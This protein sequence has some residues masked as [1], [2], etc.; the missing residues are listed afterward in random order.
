MKNFFFESILSENS[1]FNFHGSTHLE[2]FRF[3]T[4]ILLINMQKILN[5]GIYK[6]IEYINFKSTFLFYTLNTYY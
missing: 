4:F 3:R 5:I 1:S 6:K 2:K